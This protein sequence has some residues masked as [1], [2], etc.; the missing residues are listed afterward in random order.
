[1]RNQSSVKI[2]GIGNLVKNLNQI[3]K[4][5]EKR[6]ERVLEKLAH[7][8]IADAKKLTPIDSGDLEASLVVGD[9]K[10]L[11]GKLYIDMGNSPETDHYAVVQHEGFRR[12]KNGTIEL[13]PGEKTQSKSSYKG[14]TPGKKY[15]DNA[16][17]I[18]ENLIIKEIKKALE[19][20]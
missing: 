13:H 9:V 15:L 5:V 16:L 20:G 12:G 11:I 18:N 6:L 1:M 17:K 8:V 19:M 3:S 7:Q 4:D 10:R 14:Y 2:V